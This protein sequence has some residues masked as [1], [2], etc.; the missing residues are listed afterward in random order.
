MIRELNFTTSDNE[1]ISITSYIEETKFLGNTIIFVHG[2]KGFKDWGFG[3]YI[4]NYFAQKGF[5]AVTFNFSHNGIG[6]NKLEFTELEK[7]SRNTFSREIRELN[8]LIS[9]FRENFLDIGAQGKLGLVGHSRGGAISL[10][11]SSKR[12]DVDAVA[13]WASV[14]KLDRYS[15]RQKDEWRKKG[16]FEVLNTRTKQVMRLGIDLLNDVEQNS[17]GSLNVENAVRNLN[18]P[19]LIAHGDQDL[20]VPIKEAEMLYNWSDKSKTEFFK[21]VAAGHTFNVVHPFNGSNEN[22]EKL[23]EKTSGFFQKSFN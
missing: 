17:T 11:T 22:F 12:N 6:E 23:L 7:F 14:A 15:K 2:F 13:V 4:G 8:E 3:P 1:K 21:L 19:L 18:K 5:Q 10:L 20:A 16:V 9:A